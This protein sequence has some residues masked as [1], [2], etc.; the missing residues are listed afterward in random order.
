[1][2]PEPRLDGLVEDELGVLVPAAGQRHHEDPGAARAPALEIEELAGVPE[3]RLALPRRGTLRAAGWRGSGRAPGGAGSASPRSSC[4]GRRAPRPAAAR[5]PGPPRRARAARG[6]VRATAPRAT[7]H[8][9]GARSVPGSTGSPVRPG[10]AGAAVQHA[11]TAGPHAVPSNSVAT[12]TEV[13]GDSAIGLAQVQPA[14][15]LTDVGH[16]TPPSRHSSP[17]GVGVLQPGFRVTVRTR[18]ESGHAAPGGSI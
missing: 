11:M 2:K 15:N 1:M 8:G 5:S 3:V 17:P 12:D 6:R 4:R 13:P 16:R 7:A 9:P 14:E 10:L 18:K